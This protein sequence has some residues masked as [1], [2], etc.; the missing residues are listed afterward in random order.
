M[1][2]IQT[3]WGPVLPKDAWDPGSP[4][5]PAEHTIKTQKM[6]VWLFLCKVSKEWCMRMK[7]HEGRVFCIICLEAVSIT[8]G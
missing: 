1:C 8:T 4:S 2:H 6:F 7:D 3:A 5:P